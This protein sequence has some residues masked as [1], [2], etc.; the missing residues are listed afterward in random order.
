MGKGSG[1]G[2]PK[3]ELPWA[4]RADTGGAGTLDCSDVLVA[5]RRVPCVP[6]PHPYCGGFEDGLKTAVLLIVE[7]LVPPAWERERRLSAGGIWGGAGVGG[8]QGLR[9]YSSAVV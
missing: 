2:L 1:E 8:S 5:V 9:G 6:H 3:V 4:T 7:L